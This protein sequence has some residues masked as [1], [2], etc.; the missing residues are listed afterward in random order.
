MCCKSVVLFVKILKLQAQHVF[1]ESRSEHNI[2][3]NIDANMIKL[4]NE[5][6]TH[7]ADLPTI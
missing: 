1:K 4:S 2:I 5:M 7:D 6:P 3:L